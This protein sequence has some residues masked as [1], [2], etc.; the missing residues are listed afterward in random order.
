MQVEVVH[1]PDPQ[2]THTGESAAPPVH[3]IAADGAEAVLHGRTRGNCLVLRPSGE[4]VLAADVFQAS[5]HDGEVG[6]EH[7]R[8][9]FVT[10]AAVADE[11]VD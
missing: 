10:V 7:G 2:D 4:L 8:A 5:V 9:E 11:G 3:Q 1:G 6:A